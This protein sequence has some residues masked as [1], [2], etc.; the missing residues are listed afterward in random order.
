VIGI[1]SEVLSIIS[2]KSILRHL[3]NVKAGPAEE[4]MMHQSL[5]QVNWAAQGNL[6]ICEKAPA[7]VMEIAAVRPESAAHNE[8]KGSP[9]FLI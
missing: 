7:V 9:G 4:P 2:D 3:T 5:I 8:R 1:V 6:A